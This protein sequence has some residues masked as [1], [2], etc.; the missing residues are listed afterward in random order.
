MRALPQKLC[1][2]SVGHH[3]MRRT[4]AQACDPPTLRVFILLLIC[5]PCVVQTS[6]DGN[7]AL[8]SLKIDKHAVVGDS[9][10]TAR[11]TALPHHERSSP[12]WN[13]SLVTADNVTC[14]KGNLGGGTEHRA[15]LTVGQAI[16]WCKNT[17]RC[18]AFVIDAAYSP[19]V[20][21]SPRVAD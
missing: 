12:L 1:L 13:A 19:E 6:G 3:D 2:I 8:G 20:C 16:A 18:A 7:T 15:N 17:S 21:R 9:D 4:P 10:N 14:Q 11:R 5:G